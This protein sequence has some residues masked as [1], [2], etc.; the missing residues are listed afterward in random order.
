MSVN[1]C[2]ILVAS[3]LTDIDVP[4]IVSIA[5]NVTAQDEPKFI[6]FY[7]VPL[8]LFSMFC[9]KCKAEKPTCRM[10]KNGTLYKT[11]LSVE[12]SHI[13][14]DRSHQFFESTLLAISY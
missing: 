9:I 13:Y 5:E 3:P 14:G 7:S 4:F 1:S 2:L 10:K 6:V 8:S 12:V 11:V